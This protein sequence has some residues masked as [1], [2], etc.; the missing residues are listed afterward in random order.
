M[1]TQKSKLMRD[2]IKER[3]SKSIEESYKTVEE[4]QNAES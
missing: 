4:L 2:V 3:M 1:E